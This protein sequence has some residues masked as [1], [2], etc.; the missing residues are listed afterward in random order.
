MVE[1][2]D[3]TERLAAAVG[4]AGLNWPTVL[5]NS[6][7]VVVFGSTAAGVASPSSD[8]DVLCVGYGHRFKTGALELITKTHEEIRTEP[9]LGSELAGHIATYGVWLKGESSWVQEI[10]VGD[11][12]ILK[13]R[14]RL[15]RLIAS[16]GR[17]WNHLAPAFQARHLTT[18]R[19]ELKRFSLLTRSVSIPPTP[20][21]DR[22]P[23]S[24]DLE[25]AAAV[26]SL[27]L[28]CGT[29]SATEVKAMLKLLHSAV[30]QASAAAE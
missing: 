25:S 10:C 27:D 15:Y 2:A 13:K 9:W 28:A 1:S 22:C 5:R 17:H 14:R 20:F 4:L 30:N 23:Y 21:L 7:E 18:V 3:L 6:D 11:H 26:L 19:R 12:A 8:I 24:A 29:A 16:G